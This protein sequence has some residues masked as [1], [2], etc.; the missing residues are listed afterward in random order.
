MENFTGKSALAIQQDFHARILSLTLTA[1]SLQTAQKGALARLKT[2]KLAYKIN[3]AH[4]LS[5]M[6]NTW[7]HLCFDSLNPTEI[8]Q[9]LHVI[10]Q[11][12]SAI[13]PDRHFTRQKKVTDRHKH[14][15]DYKI[16]I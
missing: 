6:K 16:F 5:M 4:A 15:M 1:I 10:G 7:I 9:W 2:R 3:F 8:A 11:S 13:R 14:H 12:V